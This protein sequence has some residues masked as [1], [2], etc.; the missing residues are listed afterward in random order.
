VATVSRVIAKNPVVQEATRER[1]EAAMKE[2]D[3][4]VNGLVQ[5]M[6]GKGSRAVG[7]LVYEMV[8]PTFADLASGVEEGASES[9]DLMT[10][11]TTHGN[12]DREWQ[13]I[14]QMREQRARAVLLVGATPTGPEFVERLKRYRDFLATVGTKLI[15]CARGP[16][17]GVPGVAS[18]Y[19]ENR[20]GMRLATEH[21]LSLG[22]RRIVFLGA[23]ANHST[24]EDRLAGFLDAFEAAGVEPVEELIV[25]TAF[26]AEPAQKALDQ[27]VRSAVPFTAVVAARDEL[28]VRALRVFRSHRIQVPEG[29][30]LVGFDDMLFVGDLTPSLTTVRVPYRELGRRAGRLLD[31]KADPDAAELLP[32]ELVIRDSTAPLRQ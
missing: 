7:F 27:L 1:V 22:H 5:S 15:L 30:S 32:V 6:Q 23:E 21:L 19:Y 9:R 20:L 4:V 16:V 12:P 11:L 31:D 8:G 13:A 10:I 26:D 29:V 25:R 17:P 24:A 3:Y 28:A 14:Q 18:V 2:L